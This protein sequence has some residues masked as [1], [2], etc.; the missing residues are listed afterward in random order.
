MIKNSVKLFLALVVVLSYVSFSEALCVTAAEVQ[1]RKG[2]NN[3]TA[4]TWTVYKYM[5]LKQKE[6]KGTWYKVSDV[7]GE[8]HWINAKQVTSA[9]KCAVVVK[10][11]TNIRV[12][13][14]NKA[15]KLPISPLDKYY[16]FKVLKYEKKNNW[17]NVMD[18]VGNKG[19]ISKDLLW[20]E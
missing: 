18:Q 6:K 9:Y 1:L 7:D 12:M 19:W 14:D 15:K 17:I 16:S 2:P 4:K 8:I 13:P 20:I 11:K 3:K 10:D 5:P